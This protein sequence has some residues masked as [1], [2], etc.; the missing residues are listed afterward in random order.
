MSNDEIVEWLYANAQQGNWRVLVAGLLSIVVLFSR[1]IIF[2]KRVDALPVVGKISKWFK[3]DRGGITLTFLISCAGALFTSLKGNH[4][5]DGKLL[6]SCMVNTVLGAGVFN[7]VKRGV[8]PPDKPP[9][10]KGVSIPLTMLLL[11]LVPS[12]AAGEYMFR[13]DQATLTA[14]TGAMACKDTLSDVNDFRLKKCRAL[15]DGGDAAKAD[16]CLVEWVA[17]YKTANE[18]CRE[19]KRVAQAAFLAREVVA[20][21]PDAKAQALSWTVKLLAAGAKVASLY[22][23]KGIVAPEVP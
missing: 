20:T 11:L 13:Y 16:Q 15:L 5:L 12:C 10:K 19:L 8:R 18:V 14:S 1:K 21:A 17:T 3:T 6:I 22:V 4:V 23:E 7:V 2:N 9:T